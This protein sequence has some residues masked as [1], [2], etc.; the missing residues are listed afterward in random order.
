MRKVYRLIRQLGVTSKYKGYYYV[1]EAVK[2]FMEIQ[3]HPIKITKDIYPS[4]AKQFKSTPVNVE[5]DIRTVINVCWESNKEAMNEIAGYPLRYKPTNSEFIDM[6]A[7]YLMQTEIET[8]Y[9]DTLYRLQY[10]KINLMLSEKIQ[11]SVIPCSFES[12]IQCKDTGKN[13]RGAEQFVVFILN[14]QK[15]V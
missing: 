13:A 2:M 14:I 10:R 4:L 8:S 11:Y 7:Y 6:M 1:A 9:P 15:Q 12:F 3:D 5:H